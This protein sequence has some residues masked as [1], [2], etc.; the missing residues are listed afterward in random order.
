MFRQ[1]KK[2][3]GVLETMAVFKNLNT[4]IWPREWI[5]FCPAEGK[6]QVKRRQIWGSVWGRHGS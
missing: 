2:I 6:S 3:F 1:E 5:Y 4:L